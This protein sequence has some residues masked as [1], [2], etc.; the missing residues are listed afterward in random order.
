MSAGG[1]SG[2]PPDTSV[3]RR[4]RR[5]LAFGVLLFFIS[6]A[7][8]EVAPVILGIYPV[9][10]AETGEFVTNWLH[11]AGFEVSQEFP[12][13]GKIRLKANK[14]GETVLIEIRSQSPLSSLVE[15][16]G[17]I[18]VKG[19]HSTT[20]GLKASLEGYVFNHDEKK[21]G[22]PL[23]LPGEVQTQGNTIVCLR[24]LTKVGPVQFSGF[25]IDRRGLII[26]TAHDLDAVHGIITDL[27]GGAE[28][29]G[30]VIKRDPIRDLSLIKVKKTFETAVSV[31][32]GR[33]QLKA[34]DRVYSIG[35]P[36]NLQ[37]MVQVGIVEGPPAMVNG[38]PLWQVNME[39]LPGSS[40]SPVFDQ[41]GRLVG[42]VKGRYR[43]TET[44]GFLIP[45]DTILEFLG[46][47]TR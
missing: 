25:V 33:R 31:N 39:V 15:V 47:G 38:Q 35:C 12:D 17:T 27:Y 19:K 23:A 42:V 1:N 3:V 22:K 11:Q 13:A 46:R 24:T 18:P 10:V 40:G 5:F 20:D 14:A 4:I 37:R 16:F 44:R 41:D 43:G 9:P 28:L 7:L 45:I 30:E 6:P 32:K 21:G 8:C 34:G 26:A 29:K 2:L 36:Q